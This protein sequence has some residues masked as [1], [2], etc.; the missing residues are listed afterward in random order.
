MPATFRDTLRISVIN[1]RDNKIRSVP[2]GLF[3]NLTF[4]QRVDLSKCRLEHVGQTAF[5]NVP[6]LTELILSENRLTTLSLD[7]VQSLRRLTGLVL[8]A[9][10]WRCDCELRPLRDWAI[11]KKLYAPPTKCAEPEHLGNRYWS[12]LNST[13]FAC[14]PEIL[15]PPDGS[16]VEAYAGD[17]TLVC[18]VSGDPPP[19]VSIGS[20]ATSSSS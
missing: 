8:H 10:P 1:L 11:E 7:A 15:T 5:H 19:M 20:L 3:N 2:N 6:A 12:D 4:L 16:V 13:D 14:R 9:N 17:V 18:K